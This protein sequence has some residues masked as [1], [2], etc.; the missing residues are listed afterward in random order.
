MTLEEFTKK[1]AA[2]SDEELSQKMDD[3]D[4][5]QQDAWAFIEAVSKEMK[6]RVKPGRLMKERHSNGGTDGTNAG[7]N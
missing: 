5:D 7:G 6:A 2:M 4:D 3:V 1:I